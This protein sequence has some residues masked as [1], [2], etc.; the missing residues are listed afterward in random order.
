MELLDFMHNNDLQ[1]IKARGAFYTW[2][3]RS[4]SRRIMSKLDRC[5][6]NSHWLNSYPQNEAEFLNPGISDHSPI[7][8]SWLPNIP[9]GPS[10][11][12]FF[13]TWMKDPEFANVLQSVWAENVTGNPM[14]RL[15]KKLKALKTSL[16]AW[17][18]EKL[19]SI[20]IQV[21][22]AK[23]DLEMVQEAI[24]VTHSSLQERRSLSNSTHTC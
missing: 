14:L 1:D 13:L 24:L 21:T 6:V 2:S 8:L 15:M 16:K 11:F 10:P 18:K 12:K 20:S 3:N 5:L 9:K 22:G 17:S 19:G 4:E 23:S 7:V